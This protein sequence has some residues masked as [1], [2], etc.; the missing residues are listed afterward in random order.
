MLGIYLLFYWFSKGFNLIALTFILYLINSYK[1]GINVFALLFSKSKF[2]EIV[3]NDEI[4][5]NEDSDVLIYKWRKG[6]N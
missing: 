6:Q 3:K 5:I 1:H 4:I 2:T